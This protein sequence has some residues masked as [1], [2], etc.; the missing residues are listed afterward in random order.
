M[1]LTSISSVLLLVLS[2]SLANASSIINCS[3]VERAQKQP[4]FISMGASSE[5]AALKGTAK[6]LALAQFELTKKMFNS[7]GSSVETSYTYK[8]TLSG[9]RYDALNIDVGGNGATAVFQEG[10]TKAAT[11]SF[12]D[13]DLYVNG[14]RCRNVELPGDRQF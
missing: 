5:I 6:R 10:T 1:K 4:N 14:R 3:D 7:P 2:Q 8:L 9:V 11:I 12:F 13:G